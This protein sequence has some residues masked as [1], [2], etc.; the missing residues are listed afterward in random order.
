MKKHVIR[1][2]DWVR[3][4]NPEMFVRCGYPLSIEDCKAELDDTLTP[5][6][7]AILIDQIGYDGDMS[8]AI[9][10]IL[11]RFAYYDLKAK[12]FGGRER[13]IHTEY[14]ESL[15]GEMV[16]VHGKKVCYTGTYVLGS[17]NWEDCDP[18]Y[19]DHPKA[20]IILSVSTG[21]FDTYRIE[22]CHVE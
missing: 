7:R 8:R 1:E 2:G 11:G 22:A 4:V 3:I 17:R 13:T 18:P 5:Q 20:H 16:Q 15:K 19:L 10:D 12:R 14:N 21:Y 6:I 9:E